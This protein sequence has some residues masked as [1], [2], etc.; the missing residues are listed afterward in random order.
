RA[1]YTLQVHTVM[2]E[3][4]LILAGGHSVDQDFR[5]FVEFNEAAFRARLA[6]EPGEQFSRAVV[7]LCRVFEDVAIQ[8]FVDHSTVPLVRSQG[9]GPGNDTQH[10][11][12][13]NCDL[14]CTRPPNAVR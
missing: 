7:D 3:E 1:T 9:E 12:N 5:Y 2:S 4:F 14:K 13:D 11:T 8:P 10:S 6:G